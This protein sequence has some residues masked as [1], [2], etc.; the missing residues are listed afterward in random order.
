MM[1]LAYS[2]AYTKENLEFVATSRQTTWHTQN[3]YADVAKN[4]F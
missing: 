2:V 4:Y 3:D 1:D